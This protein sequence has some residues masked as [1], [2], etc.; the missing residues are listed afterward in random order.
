MDVPA[1]V[2]DDQDDD[3]WCATLTLGKCFISGPTSKHV[4]DTGSQGA[5]T[6]VTSNILVTEDNTVSRNKWD[7]FINMPLIS[8][9]Q[10]LCAIQEQNAKGTLRT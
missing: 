5:F 1:L 10:L 6:I 8:R 3:Y 7:T 4:E 9:E 2:E